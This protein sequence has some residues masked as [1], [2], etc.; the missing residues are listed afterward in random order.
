MLVLMGW[1]AF[2]AQAEPQL[3]AW[4]EDVPGTNYTSVVRS[5]L[6][7]ATGS[8]VVAMFEMRVPQDAAAENPSLVLVNDLIAA[9]RRGVDVDVVLNLRSKYDPESDEPIR[10]HAN[11]LAADMLSYAGVYVF[12]FPAKCH[13]HAKLVIIDE[14]TTII[15]SHNWTYSGLA[16]NIES[17]SLIRSREHAQAKLEGIAE[18][19]TISAAI[20]VSPDVSTTI[21]IPRSFL[22]REGLAPYMMTKNDERP[23][24]TYLIFKRYAAERGAS[25]FS[26]DPLQLAADLKIAP[27]RDIWA[28]RKYAIKAIRSLSERYDLIDV[29]FHRGKDAA[30]TLHEDTGLMQDGFVDIPLAYWTYGLAT[31]LKQGEKYAYLICL[32][33]EA[34][35][36]TP[37]LW[38]KNQEQIAE[39]YSSSRATINN[40]MNGLQRHDLLTIIRDDIPLNDSDKRRPNHYRL[41]RLLSPEERAAR[42]K[43]LEEKHSPELLAQAR[44]LATM[45]DYGN[46]FTSADELAAAITA[47]G[48]QTVSNIT[49]QV[50][51]SSV[52]NPNRHPDTVTTY[53]HNTRGPQ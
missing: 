28:Q 19:Q 14:R 3:H 15:G 6:V 16:Q 49:A 21:P 30:I 38:K 53:L 8:V 41:K 46:D 27:D 44:G 7:A 29:T 47:Y 18:L 34:Q 20:T 42:W 52:T 12:Y 24:D 23:F 48:Y 36:I 25:S 51:Q 26:V 43:K 40:A 33:E 32:N 35:S 50:A 11:G 4:V 9:H 10:D 17:S 5:E 2:R 37:P 31:D 1:L 22:L 45:V 39:K 13:M